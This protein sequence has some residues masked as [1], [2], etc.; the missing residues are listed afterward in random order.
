MN[1]GWHH[2]LIR[3]GWRRYFVVVSILVLIL[4]LA[5]QSQIL[6]ATE[7]LSHNKWII[8]FV[9]CI[10]ENGGWDIPWM[11]LNCKTTKLRIMKGLYNSLKQLEIL[12]FDQFL[13]LQMNAI[14]NLWNN[15]A[16]S[17][18]WNLDLHLQVQIITVYVENA[19]DVR[20]PQLA[21]LHKG[22]WWK[23]DVGRDFCQDSAR[24]SMIMT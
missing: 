2:F 6:S 1:L 23:M 7:F 15:C 9:L 21:L 22:N 13:P 12:E 24:L 17:S 14:L 11:T 16:R 3:K 18:I 20:Q 10:L 4:I 19:S 8:M 5:L